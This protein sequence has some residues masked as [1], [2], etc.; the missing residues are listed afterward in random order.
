MQSLT[1]KL[2]IAV[3]K[4]IR[5]VTTK[6]HAWSEASVFAMYHLRVFTN[7]QMRMNKVYFILYYYSP[8]RFGRC[9]DHHQGVAQKHKEYTNFF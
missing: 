8:T 3:T 7:Q 1:V 2:A 9:S 5:P 4:G 6:V